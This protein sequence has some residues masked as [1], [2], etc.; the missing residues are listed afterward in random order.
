MKARVR[1]ARPVILAVALVVGLI[2]LA[3]P[4]AG[5]SDMFGNVGP[6]PEI[7]GGALSEQYP[8]GNYT[9]DQHFKAVEASLTGG[10]DVSGVPPMIAYFLASVIWE[11]TAFLARALISLFTFA[12]SLDLLNG[13]EATGGAGALRPVAAAI[14]TIYAEVFGRPWLVLAVVVVGM[15]AMWRALIQ[16]RYAETAGTLAVSLIYLIVALAFVAQPASTIGSASSWTNQMSGA[17]LSI[18]GKG[19]IGQADDAKLSGADQLFKLLIQQPWAV[20]QFG[21]IEHCAKVGTGSDDSDPESVPVRPLSRHSGKDAALSRTLRRGDQVE[22]DGKTCINNL[23]K[24]APHFL[25][26]PTGSD[27]RDAEYDALNSGD[28][29]KLPDSDPSADR[30]SYRLSVADKPATDAMEEGGQYQRLLVAIVVFVGELGVF[31]LIGALSIGVILAQ[32][33]LLLMLAFAP[34]VLVVAV[35]PGRG[36]DFF[37]GW[38]AKLAGLLVRKAAYSLILAILLA[39][40][41]ALASATSQLGWLMSFGLQALFNWMVFL[42]RRQLTSRLIG[43]TG[44]EHAPQDSNAQLLAYLRRSTA[45]RGIERAA[46]RA[47]RRL[48]TRRGR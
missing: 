10:V 18:T 28:T 48:P 12:F 43:V 16:R 46:G 32:I 38:L 36:H 6:A 14:H 25:P 15:W 29:E 17:F 9:L 23:N 7:S 26:H 4:L 19:S 34:V 13:S 45:L 37:R 11:L 40:N 41:G 1:E 31:L 39:V 30:G 2:A 35:I 27:E 47:S 21:G 44:G 3:N 24:Y 33:L 42:Q 20:L 8:H 5:A 22:A